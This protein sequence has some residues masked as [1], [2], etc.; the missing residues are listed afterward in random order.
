MY[1]SAG[2]LIGETSLYCRTWRPGVA[3]GAGLSEVKRLPLAEP[4]VPLPVHVTVPVPNCI[5]S[6]HDEALLELQNTSNR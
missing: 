4:F 1:G 3:A 6:E 5:V 2:V